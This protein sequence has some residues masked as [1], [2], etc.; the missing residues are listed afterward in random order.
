MCALRFFY[1]NI[2]GSEAYRRSICCFHST[3][4]RQ[5][6]DDR[7]CIAYQRNTI[8]TTILECLITIGEFNDDKLGVSCS[9]QQSATEKR[10]VV[11]LTVATIVQIYLETSY[12]DSLFVSYL[13]KLISIGSSVIVVKL[14]N[15]YVFRSK[16]FGQK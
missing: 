9:V 5:K 1:T 6:L 13:D 12:V 2:Y 8:L 11:G 4:I 7:V 14:I 3:F 16:L 10:T 15:P